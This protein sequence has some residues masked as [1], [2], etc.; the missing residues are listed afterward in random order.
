[1]LF[2]C[3]RFLLRNKYTITVS[4]EPAASF[5]RTKKQWPIATVESTNIILNKYTMSTWLDVSLKWQRSGWV[6]WMES[7]QMSEKLVLLQHSYE[8]PGQSERVTRAKEC[9]LKALSLLS[10]WL[11]R[12]VAS[13]NRHFSFPFLC[14]K[15]EIWHMERRT[16]SSLPSVWQMK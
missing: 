3:N 4:V 2:Y 10:S 14:D 13:C 7:F 9:E 12:D 5:F 8:K 6:Q 16:T 15:W 1:M 11:I